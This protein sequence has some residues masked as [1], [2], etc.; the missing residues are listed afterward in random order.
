MGVMDYSHL[1][2]VGV[3]SPGLKKIFLIFNDTLLERV[4]FCYFTP[5]ILG[6]LINFLGYLVLCES[7]SSGQD[8]LQDRLASPFLSQRVNDIFATKRTV[9]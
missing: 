3:K 8:K 5:I 9:F 7:L 4:F 2:A 1:K 6:S